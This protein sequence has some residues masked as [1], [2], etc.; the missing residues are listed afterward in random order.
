MSFYSVLFLQGLCALYKTASG[1]WF[2]YYDIIQATSSS[3]VCHHAKVKNVQ[4]E[5][6][7]FSWCSGEGGF[8][9]PESP[10]IAAPLSSSLF[11]P[12]NYCKHSK[13]RQR[14]QINLLSEPLRARCGKK[15]SLFI[16]VLCDR[17]AA[18]LWP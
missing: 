17:L 9:T 10:E 16:S 3:S 15:G 11:S 6:E 7:D 14:S 8:L 1:C 12:Q 2:Y 18:S 4:T 5:G 13:G